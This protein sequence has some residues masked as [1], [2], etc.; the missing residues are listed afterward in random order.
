MEIWAELA[1]LG[2]V[3][4]A[5]GPPALTATDE[6]PNQVDMPT[7]GVGEYPTATLVLDL[8]GVPNAD[9]PDVDANA[10]PDPTEFTDPYTALVP[11]QPLVPPVDTQLMPMRRKPGVASTTKWVGGGRPRSRGWHGGGQRYTS[12]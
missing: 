4:A 9:L 1:R 3:I 6:E 2:A 7:L 12:S 11:Q 5:F 8:A 10:R